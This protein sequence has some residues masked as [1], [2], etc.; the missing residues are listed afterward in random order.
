[1][2]YLE[3]EHINKHFRKHHVIKDLSLQVNAGE[4]FGF[5]GPNGTGKTTVIKMVLGF[6]TPDSGTIRICGID[7]K[8]NFEK[9]MANV[10][11]IV[12]NPDMYLE[13]SA[14]DNLRFYAKLQG[15]DAERIDYVVRL[16]HLETR[17]HDKVKKYSLGMKQRLGLAMALLHD[18]K[19]LMLDEPTNGL[20]PAGIQEL[21]NIL[22]EL[23]H[24]QKKAIFVS[25]HLLSEMQLICDRVGIID[26]GTLVAIEK[27][28]NITANK[29]Q[30]NHYVME[31]EPVSKAHKLLVEYFTDCQIV[32]GD[33]QFSALTT[34]IPGILK[35]LINN[36]CAV[37]RI[38][39][40]Q[41]NLEKL[42]LETVGR[43]L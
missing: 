23:A 41:N 22:K 12:E 13:F 17:I 5:L 32:D 7:L 25:S 35:H 38:N 4:V 9:A 1:M 16:M 26:Q 29:Q 33:L 19:L 11:G 20:D 8:E 2:V 24:E 40:Q 18:P 28:E 36:D 27:I 42:F 37:F 43:K 31:V 6:L 30:R 10:G 39:Y 3:L 14:L 21:R 15:V 34:Q